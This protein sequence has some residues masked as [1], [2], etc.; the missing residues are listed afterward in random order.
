MLYWAKMVVKKNKKE[1]DMSTP[2]GTFISLVN[3]I[4]DQIELSEHSTNL[5]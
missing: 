2:S 1:G 5:I 3:Y 4:I